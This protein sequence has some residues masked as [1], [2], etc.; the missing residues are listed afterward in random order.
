MRHRRRS[1]ADHLSSSLV[2]S[3]IQSFYEYPTLCEPTRLNFTSSDDE[4]D[5]QDDAG[6]NVAASQDMLSL[7]TQQEKRSRVASTLQFRPVAPSRS[8]VQNRLGD[9]GIYDT[10][11]VVDSVSYRYLNHSVGGRQ[12]GSDAIKTCLGYF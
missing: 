1:S 4:E 7:E 8:Q 5:L 6:Q 10:R 2:K 9:L 3:P 11:P 12:L